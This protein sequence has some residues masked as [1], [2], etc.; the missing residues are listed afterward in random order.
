MVTTIANLGRSGL[1]DWLFQRVSA[2]ILAAYTVFIVYFLVSHPQLEFAAWHQLFDSFCMRVFTLLALVSVAGHGW[3][4]F[5]AVLTDY[6]TQ[7]MMGPKAL[8]MRLILLGIYFIVTVTYLVWGI[9]ILWR[10]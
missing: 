3:I 1:Y 4:G 7:R 5:W 2:V 9:E 8:P 10:L 6:V